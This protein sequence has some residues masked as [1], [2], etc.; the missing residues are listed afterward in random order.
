MMILTEPVASGAEAEI[1]GMVQTQREESGFRSS[2]EERSI[3]MDICTYIGLGKLVA[4]MNST[5][6]FTVR[7]GLEPLFKK[8]YRDCPNNRPG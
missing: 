5:V 8:S 4:G 2:C 3:C 1:T 7:G 6:A